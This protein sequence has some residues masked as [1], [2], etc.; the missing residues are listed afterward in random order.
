M[1]VSTKQARLKVSEMQVLT[2]GQGVVSSSKTQH[3]LFLT[4]L[5][6]LIQWQTQV[7][8]EI[9]FQRDRGKVASAPGH[10]G[11]AALTQVVRALW[12]PSF[13]T[14]MHSHAL[15]YIGPQRLF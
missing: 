3:G 8:D 2:H 1:G 10:E 14:G 7:G 4:V 9:N 15:P 11:D 6:T 13:L 5:L 12:F